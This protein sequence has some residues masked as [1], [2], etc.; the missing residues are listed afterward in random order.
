MTTSRL[1]TAMMVVAAG[2]LAAE[3]L[4]KTL[5]CELCASGATL[6]NQH[7]TRR[8]LVAVCVCVF[9]LITL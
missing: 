8:S 6:R 1:I 9:A 3:V 4:S 5:S 2:M 7:D